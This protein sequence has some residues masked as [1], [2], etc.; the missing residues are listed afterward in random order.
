MILRKWAR[1]WEIPTDHFDADA[2][3]ALSI[4]T[5]ARPLR[6]VLVEGSTYSRGNLKRRLFAE[7]LKDRECEICGQKEL[8]HGRRMALIL[9][10]VNGVRDDNRLENLRIVCPNCAATLDTHCG[11]KLRLDRPERQC[12]RCGD[13]FLPNSSRQRYCSRECGQRATRAGRPSLRLRRVERPPYAQLVTEIDRLGYLAVGRRY[14]V[15]DN[16][17]RKWVRHYE[18]E[19]RARAATEVAKSELSP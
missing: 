11:R 14:G 6:E 9:D 7:G 12:L 1:I 19:H 15:S 2:V 13:R 10:H 17:I 18:R 4:G 16:A 5:V 3:R 8:W